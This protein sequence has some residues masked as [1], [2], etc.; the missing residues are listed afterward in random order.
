M[1]SH[2]KRT[3]NFWQEGDKSAQEEGLIIFWANLLDG[4]GIPLE[5]RGGV[6]PFL[7]IFVSPAKP[8]STLLAHP[9]QD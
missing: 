6:P 1:E 8:N 7:P 5:R 3:E 4:W 2:L 9:N